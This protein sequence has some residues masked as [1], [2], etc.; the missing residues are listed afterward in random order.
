MSATAPAAVLRAAIVADAA[1]AAECLRRSIRTLCVDDHRDDAAT[2]DAW[3]ANKTAARLARWIAAPDNRTVVALRASALAGLGMLDL[4]HARITLL[5]VD[6]AARFA[7][8][9]DAML[10]WLEAAARDA[11]LARL[12]LGATATALSFYRARGWHADGPPAAGL[13]ISRSH[14]LAKLLTDSPAADGAA[15]NSPA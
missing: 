3:L 10:G 6:P 7:G 15:L 8:V 9:S 5:Y 14:P 13:G 1:A 12:T 4:A 11:G 2:L